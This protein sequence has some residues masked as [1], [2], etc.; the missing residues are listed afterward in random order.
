MFGG[1][2]V[3]ITHSHYILY[4]DID[5]LL[6]RFPRRERNEPPPYPYKLPAGIDKNF[7]HNNLCSLHSIICRDKISIRLVRQPRTFGSSWLPNKS[8]IFRAKMN[9]SP[10]KMQFLVD[11][12]QKHRIFGT[13]F[14]NN[15]INLFSIQRCIF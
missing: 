14:P 9:F 2:A 6:C 1:R 13:Q 8:C 7:R 5:F 12:V 15:S 10:T 4:R 11:V 3:N